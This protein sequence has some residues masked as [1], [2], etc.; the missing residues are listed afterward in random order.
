MTQLFKV[1]L[2]KGSLDKT[3]VVAAKNVSN[4]HR[5]IV[6]ACHLPGG[7]SGEEK[8]MNRLFESVM[9]ACGAHI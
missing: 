8:K 2:C 4:G 3:K 5:E 6:Q 7:G 1:G 9:A